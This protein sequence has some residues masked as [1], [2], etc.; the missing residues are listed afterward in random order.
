MFSIGGQRV[1]SSLMGPCKLRA[2][3]RVN[4]LQNYELY[5]SYNTKHYIASMGHYVPSG[6]GLV[7][8][9]HPSFGCEKVV[10]LG[11]DGK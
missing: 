5:F 10:G 2:V 1:C 9:L 3:L 6:R 8:V 11:K 4:V 7:G